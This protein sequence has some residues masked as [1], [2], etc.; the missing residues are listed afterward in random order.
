MHGVRGGA[1][2]GARESRQSD[3]VAFLYF[4]FLAFFGWGKSS[5]ISRN[6][7]GPLIKARLRDERGVCTRHEEH[8]GR[9]V[10]TVKR[11]KSRQC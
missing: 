8:L 9:T 6:S 7:F 2:E 1:P 10:L 5:R 3:L 11:T 4:S